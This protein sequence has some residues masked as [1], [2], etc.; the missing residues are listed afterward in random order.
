MRL[1]DL[2]KGEG[3]IISGFIV[4]DIRYTCTELQIVFEC[5]EYLKFL[6]NDENYIT[7]K[8]IDWIPITH[9]CIYNANGLWHY[10]CICYPRSIG[11]YIDKGYS[12]SFELARLLKLELLPAYQSIPIKYSLINM[13]CA[14]ILGKIMEQS[15]NE[16]YYN[17]DMGEA[18]F[19]YFNSKYLLASDYKT[20]MNKDS[21]IL[22]DP[23]FYTG[24]N[25]VTRFDERLLNVY[26]SA[27]GCEI[28]KREDFLKKILGKKIQ[29]ET[30]SP[31][32]FM[33]TYTVSFDDRNEFNEEKKYLCVRTE[34]NITQAFAY[35]N[36]YSEV[37]YV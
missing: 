10:D 13:Y 1:I 30:A 20:I 14:T 19:L 35:K 34:C 17:Q 18:L 22:Q 15:F 24:Q 33:S 31:S 36:I 37:L 16:A 6:P 12:N 8:E 11:I 21:R 29:I 32:V 2:D 28:Y 25:I 26:N 27:R 7:Y 9:G 4:D 3:Q 5:S 23:A